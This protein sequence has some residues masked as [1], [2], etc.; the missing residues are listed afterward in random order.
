MAALPL[1]LSIAGAGI[2]AA[3]AIGQG[4]AQANAANYQAQVASNNAI[5]SRQNAAHAA[6]AS[7][8]QT[9]QAGLKAAQQQAGVRT[10][11]AAN[12]IDVNSG[13]AADV[14]ESQRKIGALDTATVANRG[15]E[16]VYGY[17]TQGTN[18]TAQSK[19]YSAEAPYDIAGGVLKGASTVLG[20]SS[21]F[22]T[23]GGRDLTG[24]MNSLLSAPSQVTPAYN[25]MLNGGGNSG[26]T[27]FE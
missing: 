8:V 24:N 6:A 5:V 15:A 9:E 4:V 13:S 14:Q 11:I 17:E 20:A 10:A 3:G 12:G 16:A 21:Q 23:G 18:Y 26:I 19:A 25:W 22:P 7:S 2:S 1:I 27:E